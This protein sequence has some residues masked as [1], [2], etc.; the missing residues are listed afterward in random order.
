MARTFAPTN[1]FYPAPG[2][3][4]KVGGFNINFS[5]DAEFQTQ[6]LRMGP[7]I[8]DRA[9]GICRTFAEELAMY[10]NAAAPRGKRQKGRPGGFLGRSFVAQARPQWEQL[11]KVGYAVRS[12]AKYH[13]YQEFGV[14]KPETRVRRFYD[15]KGRT[16]KHGQG[17]AGS[18][19]RFLIGTNKLVPGVSVRGDVR[20]IIIQ[21]NPF[22]GRVVEQHRVSFQEQARAAMVRYIERLSSTGSSGSVSGRAA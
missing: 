12:K 6:L 22:F 16:P 4:S 20:D 19:Y 10:A 2:G 15:A 7:Q 11:G 5:G 18:R 21:A 13:H 17:I 8:I 9:R 3:G 14:N 1:R